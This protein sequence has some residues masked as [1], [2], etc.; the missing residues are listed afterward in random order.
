MVVVVV[1]VETTWPVSESTTSPVPWFNPRLRSLLTPLN[2]PV[3]STGTVSD[4]LF[5]DVFG[6]FS[7]LA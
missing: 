3:F 5:M 2:C 1:T 7:L 4:D 6:S